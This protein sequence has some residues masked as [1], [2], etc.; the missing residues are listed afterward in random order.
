MQRIACVASVFV[1]VACGCAPRTGSVGSAPPPLLATRAART[2]YRPPP[3]LPP[4]PLPLPP[5]PAPQ[6]RPVYVPP[7]PTPVARAEGLP[8]YL[9]PNSSLLRGK[10]QVIVVHHSATTRDNVKTMDRHHRNQGWDGLGYH[11][12]IGNGVT[13]GDGRIY[14]GHRWDSQKTGAH[15]RA[16]A[17]RY[18]NVHRPKNFFNEHGVGICLIGNFEDD[19]PTAK[20]MASLQQL[21]AALCSELGISADKVYG[22]G[23]VTGSTA[24]PGRSLS[25]QLAGLR[26]HVAQ[27]VAAGP[28]TPGALVARACVPRNL[29]A[30]VE[31]GL[32]VD[33]LVDLLGGTGHVAWVACEPP[34]GGLA[35]A[36][37]GWPTGF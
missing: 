13:T 5:R 25:A 3:P 33:E 26:S 7:P 12:V 6:P 18:F 9:R 15:C 21:T 8:S 37:Q 31:T 30:L 22:H 29:R 35:L 14:K 16:E 32:L 11:F 4:K 1:L 28:G 27:R 19:R 34:A 36:G 2:T 20:Q 17:G 10:W 24:C 23:Q